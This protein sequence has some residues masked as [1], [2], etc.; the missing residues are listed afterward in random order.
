MAE[1]LVAPVLVWLTLLL[2]AI[3]MFAIKARSDAVRLLAVDAI[4]L[5]LVAI[6][7]LFSIMNQQSYYLDA[8]LA[9]ALVSFISTVAAARR[10]SSRR[11]L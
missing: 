9:L 3:G 4:T 7:A 6:L 2:A 1:P 8:A 11:V 5:M 10:L